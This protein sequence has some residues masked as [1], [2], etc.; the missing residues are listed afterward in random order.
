MS[1]LQARPPSSGHRRSSGETGH[2]RGTGSTAIESW[3]AKWVP[4]VERLGTT[5]DQQSVPENGGHR[6]DVRMVRKVTEVREGQKRPEGWEAGSRC[7]CGP[8]HHFPL[9]VLGPRCAV[10]GCHGWGE[11]WDWGA[12]AHGVSKLHK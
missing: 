5:G 12:G 10:T 4:A 3:S 9:L 11:A 6:G 7:S 1:P 2:F 8:Q